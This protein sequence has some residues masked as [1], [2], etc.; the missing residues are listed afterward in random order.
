MDPLQEKNKHWASYFTEQ[1]GKYA[2]DP[3]RA[4]DFSNEKLMRQVH[5]TILK[6]LDLEK[7]MKILDAGCGFG[8]LAEMIGEGLQARDKTAEFFGIDVSY[9]M[10]MRAKKNALTSPMPS[11]FFLMDMANMGF[12]K[13]IFD[14]SVCSESL[15]YSEPY[16]VLRELL[17][18]TLHRLVIS[19][20]NAHDDI[21]RRAVDK[22]NGKYTAPPLR[23]LVAFLTGH[24]KCRD[25]KV[26]PLIF[27]EDQNSYPYQESEFED[28]DNLSLFQIR[29]ANRF[30]LKI[31][32]K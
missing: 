30:V 24:E 17:R 32:L 9:G 19:V 13:N 27:A 18:V 4:L 2:E 12:I 21:I 20:P 15:Q 5:R 22:N 8:S 29:N 25:I 11:H 14:C 28:H 10:V 31:D 26:Y 6:G 1:A 23:A 7:G 3:A 16:K